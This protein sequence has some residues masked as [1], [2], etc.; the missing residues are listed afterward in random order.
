MYE[1]P[2][3]TPNSRFVDMPNRLWIAAVVAATPLLAMGRLAPPVQHQTGCVLSMHGAR[4][5]Q[6]AFMSMLRS[7]S[8]RDEARARKYN[9]D[10]AKPSDVEL[11]TDDDVCS[12]AASAYSYVV[13][14]DEPDRHVTVLQVGDRYVVRDPDFK[15]GGH[16]RAVTFDSSFSEA[17]AVVV[18]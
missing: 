7:H 10:G 18:E 4:G 1:L 5:E 8:G 14:N 16:K 2:R 17:L 15:P 6:R 12:R 13:R 3:A 11:V 9:V